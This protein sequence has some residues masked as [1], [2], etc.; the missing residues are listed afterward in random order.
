VVC[1]LDADDYISDDYI[2]AGLVQKTDN[3]IVYSDVQLFGAREKR[4][5][6]SPKFL[7][8]ESYLHVACLA[9]RSSIEAAEAFGRVPPV[10]CHEDWVF[11]R[12]LVRAGCPTTKQDGLHYHR[13]HIQ[14]RS[15]DLEV[16]PFYQ[17]KGICCDTVGF[18]QITE[19]ELDSELLVQWFPNAT[20]AFGYTSLP[21]DK[22][23]LDSFD[24]GKI[25][26]VS[27][28][29]YILF[30]DRAVGVD[31]NSM[32]QALK[33]GVVAVQMKDR[34]VW[35]GTLVTVDIL[36]SKLPCLYEYPFDGM[37]FI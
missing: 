27:T 21:V 25:L 5:V 32:L 1:F 37:L 3:N 10:G 12:R 11:W 29:D 36:R 9:S 13:E 18:V 16:L 24:I 22:H 19:E 26:R 23:I 7:S 34:P 6:Y 35:A 8:Q 14:N 31:V 28:A 17:T 15:K 4:L 30:Y 2:G 33:H 20:E